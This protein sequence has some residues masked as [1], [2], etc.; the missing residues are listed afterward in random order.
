MWVVVL[1]ELFHLALEFLNLVF[2]EAKSSNPS[3]FY[4]S[5]LDLEGRSAYLT[6]FVDIGEH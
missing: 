6:Y 3:F 1:L 2:D 4:M 5:P